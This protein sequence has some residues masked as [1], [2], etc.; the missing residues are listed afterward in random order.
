MKTFKKLI[1]LSSL[2]CA[3]APLASWVTAAD[4]VTATTES[5]DE[6]Y[7]LA[8]QALS[9]EAEGDFI[10]RQRL[11]REAE[12]LDGNCALA[13][14]MK[15]ELRFAEE[16]VSVP[17]FVDKF[18]TDPL[19]AEYEQQRGQGELTADQHFS[20]GQWCAQNKLLL[21]AYGH[22]NRAL[23]IDRIHV[24]AMR[25]LGYQQM[26][27]EWISPAQL[28][29]AQSQADE[30]RLSI[31]K[32]R[33]QVRDIQELLTSSRRAQ[34][35]EGREKLL[36]LQDPAAIAAVDVM[37][38][39]STVE[40]A[41]VVV[42]WMAALDA[43]RSS[44]VLSRFALLHPNTDLRRE[45]TEALKTRPMHDYVPQLIDM[46]VSPVA[47]ML[48]P[49]FERDGTLAGYRQAFT[50]E[51]ATQTNLIVFDASYERFNVVLNPAA[52]DS[53]DTFVVGRRNS[54]IN[55]PLERSITRA[56]ATE[57]N[58]RQAIA[59][60][61]NAAIVAR[62]TRIAELLGSISDEEIPATPN[63]I[64]QWWDKQNES[65][66]Q[67]SKA[68][69]F[70]RQAI[71][72]AVPRYQELRYSRPSNYQA[73]PPP[74]PEQLAARRQ[75]LTRLVSG[76]I[77]RAECLVAGTPVMTI[78]GLR[79]IESIRT[80]DL[81]LTR[82]IQSG[83]LSWK[84]VVDDTQRAPESIREI[85]LSSQTIRCTG[86]HLF[87]V[88]GTGWSKASELKAG[89]VLHT[90]EEPTVVAGVKAV[91]AEPTFN[92]VVADNSNYF[93]GPE[94][95]LTHDVTARESTRVRV[96]GLNDLVVSP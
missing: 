24:P 25:A 53:T 80:G 27:S 52:G 93:V 95:V 47:T 45:A 20:L 46:T 64:W 16:W 48:V 91:A 7:Q 68:T 57:T 71:S 19:L 33:D 58:Q 9:A 76:D 39:N 32:F 81:V 51:T 13:R 82:D 26:G 12:L 30:A 23:Q 79:A 14:S 1:L 66:T 60:R 6:A 87:W 63:G 41:K 4:P 70:N 72:R 89:D 10:A 28:Q 86:G 78:R 96:P 55:A 15:N 38:S 84:P 56:A 44:Q 11:L 74:S 59:Q 36:E 2:A 69:N 29:L 73:L 83:A 88:S 18:A 67:G 49:V 62:N 90:A 75:M 65:Q 50:Q 40:V 94:L 77:Q 17:Q 37:L 54:A 92:L 31:A 22:L 85:R 8:A 43:V 3:A 35:D 21:Q 5:S 61:D 42:E 34:R